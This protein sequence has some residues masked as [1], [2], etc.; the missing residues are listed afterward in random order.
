[1]LHRTPPVIE[2]GERTLLSAVARGDEGAVHELYR[3]HGDAVM[4]FI[5]R[6]VD[7][8]LEDAE[9]ITVDTFLTAVDLARGF[10]PRSSVRT[11]L[12]GIA[13]VRIIDHYRRRDRSHR[14]PSSKVEPLDERLASGFTFEQLL[15]DLEARRV[16]DAML[17]ELSEDEREALRLRYG[18][19][20]STREASI[21][22]NRT[23]RAVESLLTRA[24]NKARA[25]MGQ[26]LQEEMR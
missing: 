1:M 21:L 5:Y 22:M 6:R 13:K 20:L 16:V 4:Q 9:D 18:D 25:K 2:D 23:E 11:W 3:K 26:W 19:E 8:R 10:D 14:I 24:R 7:E 12:C 17:A 15:E